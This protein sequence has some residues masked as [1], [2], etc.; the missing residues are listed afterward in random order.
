L[1]SLSFGIKGS[2][3]AK[4]KKNS[5][6]HQMRIG[7]GAAGIYSNTYSFT[8]P[9]HVMVSNISLSNLMRKYEYSREK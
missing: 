5:R 2:Y 6:L 1:Y 8:L 4:K 7:T 9:G 3:K